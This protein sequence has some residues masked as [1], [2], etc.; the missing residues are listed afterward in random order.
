MFVPFR[1]KGLKSHRAVQGSQW[2]LRLKKFL[3]C[4]KMHL[5][6]I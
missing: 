3:D 5:S 2:L 6:V 4:F 1:A